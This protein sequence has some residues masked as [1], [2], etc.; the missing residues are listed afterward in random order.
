MPVRIQPCAVSLALRRR[1]C[2]AALNALVDLINRPGNPQ[3]FEAEPGGAASGRIRFELGDSEYGSIQV[4][5]AGG[6][7]G[8]GG[9][10]VRPLPRPSR[11]P[12]RPKGAG[13]SL[14]SASRLGR[15]PGL[16][17]TS[18]RPHLETQTASKLEAQNSSSKLRQ[19]APSTA[20]IILPWA[21]RR[22]CRIN[23]GNRLERGCERAGL[24]RVPQVAC[25][26][27]RT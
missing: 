24:G 18:R 13:L 21:N 15:L 3:I 6:R 12:S 1:P 9:S 16:T 7:G 23:A 8:G 10:L 19:P 26:G 27:P 2:G 11:A 14:G 5:P 4:G 25:G 17:R 20:T 22:V